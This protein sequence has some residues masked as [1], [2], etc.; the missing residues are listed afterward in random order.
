MAGNIAVRIRNFINNI[1][2]LISRHWPGL[3]IGPRVLPTGQDILSAQRLLIEIRAAEA[4]SKQLDLGIFDEPQRYARR[5]DPDESWLAA[6]SVTNIR[7]SQW[8]VYQ[9]L[10]SYGPLIDEELV[11][12]MKSD[13]CKQARSGIRTRRSELTKFGLVMST[14]EKRLT[15]YSNPAT[16][17]RARPWSRWIDWLKDEVSK[18]YHT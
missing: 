2:G 12:L 15:T 17:W 18:R 14:T 8:E 10:L 5:T 6:K 11:M 1:Y 13:G 4:M 16:V 9:A 3:G 7:R